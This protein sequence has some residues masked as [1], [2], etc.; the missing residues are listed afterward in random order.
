LSHYKCGICAAGFNTFV[1]YNS[2]KCLQEKPFRSVEKFLTQTEE[3]MQNNFKKFDNEKPRWSLLPMDAVEEVVKV[4]TFGAHKYGDNN[5]LEHAD[6]VKWS[7]YSSAL[8]RHMAKFQTGAD[9]DVDSNLP[10]LAHIACNALM[11]LAYQLHAKGVDDR[12]K[13]KKEKT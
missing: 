1:S 2:H 13:A 4:L 7:R 9:K 10:E 3:V 8:L 6:E 11:L 5:W 12:F